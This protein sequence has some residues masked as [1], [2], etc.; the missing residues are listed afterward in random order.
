MLAVKIR[1]IKITKRVVA[2]SRI[3]VMASLQ[4]KKKKKMT[5]VSGST[6]TKNL[7]IVTFHN[8]FGRNLSFIVVLRPC[9]PA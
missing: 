4:S 1:V 5:S 8:D 2:S 7:H 9:P 6:I 3:K